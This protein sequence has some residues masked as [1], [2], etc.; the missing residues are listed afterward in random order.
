MRRRFF[1][2][3]FLL[4]FT[5]S[6]ISCSIGHTP[7]SRTGIELGTYVKITIVVRKEG[8]MKALEAIDESFLLIRKLDGIFD[9]RTEG[10]ALAVFNNGTRLT[11]KEDETLFGLLSDAMAIAERTGGFFDPTV[12]PLVQVWGF[13]TESPHLPSSQ[14]IRRAIN[15]V[16]YKQVRVFETHAEKPESVK[17]DL[18][19][20]AKGRIVDLVRL[21]L[22][23]RGYG[24]FLIDAGG[25]IYVSGKNIH[26]K[27]WKIAIQD[28]VRE[29]RFSGIVEKSDTAIVTSGDY[30]R[31][32]I[33]ND[34]R[35]SHLFNPMTGYPESDL[36]S[37]T[38]LHRNTTYADAVATAVFV[39][40]SGR[41]YEY[42]EE[43]GIEGHL[44]FTGSDGS[45]QTRSTPRFWN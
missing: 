2:P 17:L 31:F 16:G 10:G 37:V 19:G 5:V 32:F 14:D 7:V 26:R 25:D 34:I 43:Q 44:I 27:K 3:A 35:Y 29:S 45:I 36:K 20:V 21:L 12:L 15:H 13:D 23:N 9:Y 11:R 1:Q 30:E 6:M 4:F 18:G 42:L 38:I 24:N 41:G 40:G 28:P 39:M 8:R 22:S 33:I